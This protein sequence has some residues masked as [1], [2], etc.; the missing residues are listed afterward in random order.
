M[1]AAGEWPAAAGD[2]A[3]QAYRES[4]SKG[5]F[6]N[7]GDGTYSYTF[8]TNLVTATLPTSGT[9]IGYDASLTHRVCIE[10]GGHS[11]AT[12]DACY[13]WVPDGSASPTTRDI[14]QTGTCQTCHGP[15]FDGHGGDRLKVEDCAA[16]HTVDMI[17]PHSGET[18]DL[19]V[20]IH[21]IH[22]GG[23]L[24]G[25]AGA[26]GEVFDDPDTTDDETAD[27][28]E[29]AIWGNSDAKHEW[30]GTSFPANISNCQVCHTGD[31][32]D[33]DAWKENPGREAC[34]SCHSDVDFATGDGHDAG[35]PLT[36]DSSCYLCHS[37]AR[38][39]AYH[40]IQANLADQDTPEFTVA[41]SVSTPLNGSYFEA[42][43]EPVVTIQLTNA[44]GT[45][46]DHTTLAYD[47][48]AE[49]C[50]TDPCAAGDGLLR[51]SYLFVAGP[52]AKR[53][54]V[55][56]TGS[57]VEVTSTSAGPFDLSSGDDLE[58]TFD[59][60][61][62]YRTKY[63]SYEGDVTVEFDDTYFATPSAATA[64]EVV[65][66][67]NDDSDFADRGIALVN[68][69]GEVVIRSRNMGDY[70][71]VALSDCN[72]NTAIFGGDTD[73]HTLTG[74]YN[75]SFLATDKGDP[76][77][78][79]YTDR[80]EY[81]LD[82]VDDLL[83]GTYVVSVEI[84]DNGRVDDTD[85]HTPTVGWVT[86][87]VGQADEELP[88]AEGCGSCHWSEDTNY[89]LVFDLP[90]HNKL[91]VDDAVDQCG[92]CHDYL[93]GDNEGDWYGGGA[94]SKRIHSV[95]YGSSLTYPVDTV[96]HDDDPAG[97][98]WNITF[99]QD[100]RYCEACHTEDGTSGSWATNSNRLA[101]GGC[102]DDDDVSAHMNINTWDPTPSDPWSG[103]EEESCNT[104]HQ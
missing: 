48:S 9:L 94:I 10:T 24:P 6:T 26:D 50:T 79:W 36:D 12:G 71:S 16:C 42:G 54:P 13:D 5:T 44:D 41:L 62:D 59:S 99:P 97:R 82:A 4:S 103:D 3:D 83:A 45:A 17:D 35:I 34:G 64:D 90:R 27:N 55:L 96:G 8:A 69:D 68:D 78:A 81:A 87:Q 14:V 28:G 73:P 72:T 46:V 22:M 11:G 21:K 32:A 93:N 18:Q 52:R 31:G 51:A 37:A 20:L 80:I 40:D 70:F 88:I 104:C 100:V 25:I 29:Y 56:H 85:Y 38:N 66:W 1:S 30:S 47:S 76:K 65:D 53:M 60:G 15:A 86:F 61:M 102:H 57:H 2:W 67:L 23:E 75:Y 89:G 84:S 39:E 63:E 98:Y 77:G 33:V 92:A 19:K 58:V 49:G 91:F 74:Y 101:C 95:H 43:E 7:N